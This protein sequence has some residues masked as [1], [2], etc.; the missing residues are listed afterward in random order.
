MRR[1]RNWF[2]QVTATP[3]TKGKRF[4]KYDQPVEDT[5]RDLL[6]SMPLF[7][8][9]DDRA[10]DT[11][12]GLVYRSTNT[13]AKGYDETELTTKTKAI[14]PYQ[15][16]EV[17]SINNII[18]E[19]DTIDIPSFNGNIVEVNIASS[20]A[21]DSNYDKRNVFLIKLTDTF[22]TWIR[23]ALLYFY[24]KIQDIQQDITN[25]NNINIGIT[26]G[27]TG[28]YLRK[29]SSINYD[30]SWYTPKFE[31]FVVVNVE[32]TNVNAILR[33]NF[34]ANIEIAS[35]GGVTINSPVFPQTYSANTDLTINMTSATKQAVTFKVTE[36]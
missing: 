28:Q 12:Q 29:N 36:L 7:N 1:L 6:D 14:M 25:I 8:E 20:L 27:T 30:Y 5:Y 15:L 34:N 22:L 11:Q 2:F 18:D 24:N 9:T 13:E 19:I 16:P 4:L 32:G 17:K 10:L 21:E 31:G 3:T 23:N 35:N 33:F 26:G